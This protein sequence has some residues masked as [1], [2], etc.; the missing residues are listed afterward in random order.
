MQHSSA[1]QA[2]RHRARPGFTLVEI[3]LVVVII[4]ILTAFAIPR[5]PVSGMRADAAVR[6]LRAEFQAAQRAAITRQSNVVVGIDVAAG[7]LRILE[8]GNND[9]LPSAGERV[10]MRPLEETVRFRAPSMGRIDGG[11]LAAA[12]T[13]TNLRDL[14]G[15]PSVVFRRDGSAS[16]DLELYLSS[17]ADQ[18][19][20]W[21][22]LMLSPS[23]GRA[24][25]WRRTSED[26][27]RLRP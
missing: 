21:R 18:P 14:D 16:S 24:E 6:T 22:G 25:A 2:P 17:T 7:R 3:A 26:W 12:F 9:E 15:L 13:G 27:R 10:R 1:P 23:T 5:L 8:D 11:A 20:S 4:G 19:N